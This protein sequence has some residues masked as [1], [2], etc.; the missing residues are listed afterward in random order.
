MAKLDK[1]EIGGALEQAA[2]VVIGAPLVQIIPVVGGLFDML[3]TFALGPV[4]IAL[5]SII[6][7]AVAV[8][9]YNLVRASMK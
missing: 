8:L 9:G 3:P 4:S 6:A 2:V 1:K 5:P 7:G